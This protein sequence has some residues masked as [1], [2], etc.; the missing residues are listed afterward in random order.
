[1]SF[2]L[3]DARLELAKLTDNLC[4]CDVDSG[5]H[6]GLVLFNADDVT[7]GAQGN[8]AYAVV[9]DG[10]VALDV[11]NDFSIQRIDVHDLHGSADFFLGVLTQCIGYGHFASGYGDRHILTS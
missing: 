6:I 8:F 2:V 7:A 9:R 1:M 3:D 11:Q 10:A 4:G 5:V